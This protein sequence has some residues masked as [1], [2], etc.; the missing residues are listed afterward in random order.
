[1]IDYYNGKLFVWGGESFINRLYE[2][3]IDSDTW[4]GTSGF[5]KPVNNNGVCIHNDYL[6]AIGGNNMMSYKYMGSTFKINLT[7]GDYEIEEIPINSL[8]DSYA[9]F[10][11]VCRDNH[12]YL[13]GGYSQSGNKNSLIHVDLDVSPPSFSLLSD[14]FLAPSARRGHAMEVYNDKLYIFGGINDGIK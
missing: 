1:M 5:Q 3:D 7:S 8:G 11:Y 2:Y 6:Y 13:F 14:Q 9:S 4:T 12:M 10:G